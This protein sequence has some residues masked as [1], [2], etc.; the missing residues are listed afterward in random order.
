MA[1]SFRSSMSRGRDEYTGFYLIV[2]LAGLALLLWASWHTYHAE[3]SRM[4]MQA[5]HWQMKFIHQ[6]TDRFDRADRQVLAA[7]PNRV[8]FE[9]LV[10]LTRE[11]GGFFLFPAMAFVFVLAAVCFRRAA[12][13]RFTG[14]LDLEGLIEEQAKGFRSTAAFVGRRLGLVEIREGQ[15]RPGDAALS[16]QE[17]VAAWAAGESGSFDE[18]LARTELLR[19]LGDVWRGSKHAAP[20]VRCMMA[21]IG[22]HRARMRAEAVAFL[23]DLAESLPNPKGDKRSGPEDALVFPADVVAVADGWL[24]KPAIAGPLLATM[25]QHFFTTPAL[26]SALTEARLKAGVLAPAQFAWLK[27][28]D[29]RLWYALHSLGFE[30]DGPKAHPHPSPRVEAIGARDHWAAERLAGRPLPVAAI[31][32]AAGAIKAAWETRHRKG[33]SPPR[34]LAVSPASGTDPSPVAVSHSRGPASS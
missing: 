34:Q 33:D 10:R 27:L 5:A 4:V 14:A 26:M 22:L 16:V 17:W 31:D 1:S 18:A 15:P 25:D 13:V 21:A 9:Q 23:G 2:I 20:H 30:V 19:Q 3:I 6:F 24:R 12:P 8:T 28:V 11:I 7:N 29:R 32:R